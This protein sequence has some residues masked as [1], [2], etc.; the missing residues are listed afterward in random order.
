[1]TV[2]ELVA[3]LVKQNPDDEVKVFCPLAGMYHVGVVQ[4][5]QPPPPGALLWRR[6]EGSACV[7]IRGVL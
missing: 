3:E 4:H 5:V 7:V 1:M 2:R 6:G